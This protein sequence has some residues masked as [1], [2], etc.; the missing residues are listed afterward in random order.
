V[1]VPSQLFHELTVE[2]DPVLGLPGH[3]GRAKLSPALPRS[4][5]RVTRMDMVRFLIVSV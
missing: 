5:A 4:T 3:S 1:W 2:G